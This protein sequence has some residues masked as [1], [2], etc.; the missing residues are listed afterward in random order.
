[1]MT[2]NEFMLALELENAETNE[3]WSGEF[4]AS[5]KFCLRSIFSVAFPIFFALFLSKVIENTTHKAGSVKK[6]AAFSKMLDLAFSKNNDKVLVDVLTFTDLE[7]KKAQKQQGPNQSFT[8]QSTLDAK[9][10]QNHAK[11]QKR[12]VIMT[13]RG[14]FDTKDVHYPLPLEFEDKPNFPALKR[15]IARLR[16]QIVELQTQEKE[17]SSEKERSILFLC[18]LICDAA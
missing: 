15:T 9:D 17:P 3:R 1:M 7:L 11:Y 13:Y 18:D 12:Y 8:T 16:R 4:T 6:L 5:C 2:V 14:E 10:G